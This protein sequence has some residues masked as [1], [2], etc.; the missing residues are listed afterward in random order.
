MRD[1][2]FHLSHKHF[3]ALAGLAGIGL[4]LLADTDAQTLLLVSI[5]SPTVLF[6]VSRRWLFSREHTNST[7]VRIFC[8]GFAVVFVVRQLFVNDALVLPGTFYSSEIQ[9]F[10]GGPLGEPNFESLAIACIGG[11]CFFQ[12]DKAIRH[13]MYSTQAILTLSAQ[14]LMW[15]MIAWGCWLSAYSI[16]EFSGILTTDS[17]FI[18]KALFHARFTNPHRIFIVPPIAAVYMAV[19]IVAVRRFA[20]SVTSLDSSTLSN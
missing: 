1:T 4:I 15:G 20:M 10:G 8:V 6:D 11:I 14:T 13:S 17:Y 2:L 12:I 3:A 16:G 5:W 7:P 19:V 9:Q 18:S